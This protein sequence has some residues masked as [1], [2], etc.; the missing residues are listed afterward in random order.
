MAMAFSPTFCSS[1][2]VSKSKL[3]HNLEAQYGFVPK[4][5]HHGGKNNKN[6]CDCT[7]RPNGA[8][9]TS[10]FR[11]EKPVFLLTKYVRSQAR[12]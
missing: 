8:T 2:L 1:S 3:L 12:D 5:C 10:I 4:H 9:I 11:L 6:S 7:I